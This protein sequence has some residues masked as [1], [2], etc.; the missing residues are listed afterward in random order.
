V[1]RG[2]APGGTQSNKTHNI[3]AIFY[4]IYRYLLM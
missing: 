3:R 4:S 2:P 1:W